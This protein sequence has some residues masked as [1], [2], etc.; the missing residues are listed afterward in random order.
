MISSDRENDRRFGEVVMT[1][2]S[3]VIEGHES[4]D[5]DLIAVEA[6]EDFT[7]GKVVIRFRHWDDACG[8]CVTLK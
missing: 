5:F 8:L 1:H 7:E 2:N 6:L 3:Q 4:L